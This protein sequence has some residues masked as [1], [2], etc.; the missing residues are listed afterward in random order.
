[1]RNRKTDILIC[2]FIMAFIYSCGGVYVSGDR[3]VPSVTPYKAGADQKIIK[4]SEVWTAPTIGEGHAVMGTQYYASRVKPRVLRDALMNTLKKS[5]LFQ[6]VIISGAAPYHLSLETKFLGQRQDMESA[7]TAR[8][9]MHYCLTDSE[10]RKVLWE[11]E[12]MTLHKV[13]FRDAPYGDHRLNWSM[14]GAIKK[15]LDKMIKALANVDL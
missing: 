4:I 10:T 11:K 2:F 9:V 1:M 12:I 13:A 3:M 14:E 7:I 15:N 5:S 8:V 6:D